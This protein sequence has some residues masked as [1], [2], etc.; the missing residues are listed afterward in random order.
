MSIR[1]ER[2]PRAALVG[3]V[4]LAVLVAAPVRAQVANT[5][6][7]GQPLFYGQNGAPEP[8]SQT[9]PQQQQ[10]VA[11]SVAPTAPSPTISAVQAQAA[12]LGQQVQTEG[13]NRATTQATEAGIITP[14]GERLPPAPPGEYET[15]VAQVLGRSVP[16][17]GASLLLPSARDFTPPPTAAVPPDYRL[18]PGD[19]ILVGLTGSVQSELR[20]TLDND[21][22][23][24]VPRVG[25]V[26]LTGVRYGDLAGA[27][28][29]RISDE[30]RDYR[31]AV[32]VTRLHGIRVYVT[33]YA[34]NPGAYTVSSLST[35][36]NAVLA[37]GGP[38]AGG[39]FRSI[40]VRR[41]GKLVSDFD[42]YDLLLRGDKSKDVVLQ[43]EDVVFIAPVGPQVALT[44]S[45][46]A[47]AIYETRPGESVAD[48]L[49]Y[50]GGLSTLADRSRTVVS[51]LSELDHRGWVQLSLADASASPVEG[52]DVL[53]L[54][55]VADY[56]R[57]LERQNILVT[58]EGQV[59][60]PGH[61][62]LPANATMA[63]AL[64]AAGGLTGRA[65]VYGAEFDRSRVQQQQQ[66]SFDEA[67]QQLEFS[68]AAAPLAQSPSDATDAALRAQQLAAARAVVDRLRAAH[69]DGRVVLETAPGTTALPL[70]TVMENNDRL[71]IPPTPTTVGVFG[72]VFRPGSFQVNP[73]RRVRDY[74]D[75]AGGSQR[76]ADNREIFVVRAN[77]SVLTRKRGVLRARVLPG[78]VVFVPVKTQ[79]ST[80]W[81]RLRDISG[82]LLGAGITAAAVV[83]L[84]N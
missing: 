82:L 22:A 3:S 49:R 73:V 65:F 19:E 75:L 42:L 11:P 10:P 59:A 23:V 77:G 4:T 53:R 61:I 83:G 54:L 74:L 15:Y 30:Y 1:F 8:Q 57:P 21:G 14:L 20:L 35:L 6:V 16:R 9:S 38:T 46:N 81:A 76:V 28:S 26:S 70:D 80:F 56:A 45:V 55:S 51:R 78:D 50:A 64:A 27:L 37:G 84:T 40:Q 39:S 68:L 72:A 36:V 5:A 17:F 44:G 67:L 48:V 43:N 25:R 29:R 33:G 52:G 24:F 12:Q 69:P 18:N 32:S 13:T 7:P 63:D 41:G 47:E 31:I 2:A 71:Y 66:R 34:A 62:Y 58:I 79:G 60:K